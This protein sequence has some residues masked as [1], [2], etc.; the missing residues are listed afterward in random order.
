MPTQKN[1]DIQMGSTTNSNPLGDDVSFGGTFMYRKRIAAI[2]ICI[3][4]INLLTGVAYLS[5]TSD[6]YFVANDKIVAI[7]PPLDETSVTHATDRFRFLYDNYLAPNDMPA[8]IAIVPDKGYYL[9]DSKKRSQLNYDALFNLTYSQMEYATSIDLTP[10][11]NKDCYYAT[12]SHWRQECLAPVAEHIA[13]VMNAS[14]APNAD[15]DYETQLATNAFT[16]SYQEVVSKFHIAPD[17]IYYLTNDELS[18]AVVYNYDNDSTSGLYDWEK[19]EDRNPYDFFLSG[20]SALMHISNPAADSNRQLII[21]RDSY[22]SSL[23]PLLVPYYKEILVI[24]IRYTMSSHLGERIQFEDWTGADALFLY[25]TLL[26]NKSL[27]L[28]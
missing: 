1:A 13:D 12:D 28:K 26:L 8:F 20:P 11:L 23:I 3:L 15:S 18:Q 4:F 9:Q 21:F 10:I 24:D 7:N 14:D 25:S 22:G 19:L 2:I 5:V 16:G 27:T 6:D 17:S